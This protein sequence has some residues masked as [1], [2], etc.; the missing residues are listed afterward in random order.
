MQQNKLQAA[1]VAGNADEVEAAFYEAL[2]NGDIDRLMACWADED[3]IVCIRPGGP[4][5]VGAAAIRAAFES[6]FGAVSLRAWPER[7]RKMQAVA[8]AVHS[9]LERIEVLAAGGPGQAWVIATNV[10]HRTAQG[11]RMVAHHASAGTKS[12]VQEVGGD[13]QVLH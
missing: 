6:M 2:Q 1:G 4:R 10:Y 12:D 7:A 3:D 5:L 13:A 11:W 9:V 8:S